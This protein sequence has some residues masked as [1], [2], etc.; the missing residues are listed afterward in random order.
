MKLGHVA[1]TVCLA[2]TAGCGLSTNES[3]EALSARDMEELGG[4]ATT[5][6]VDESGHTE[7]VSLWFVLPGED[8]DMLASVS[9][10]VI[11][12]AGEAIVLEELFTYPVEALAAEGMRPAIPRAVADAEIRVDGRLAE[13]DLPDRFYT[14]LAEGDG[15]LAFGQIVLTLTDNFPVELVQFK[16]NGQDVPVRDGSGVERG[17]PVGA[18]DFENLMAVVPD[19]PTILAD[20]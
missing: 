11:E 4:D 7:V 6:D 17:R 15:R 14:D 20:D 10:S 3:P 5:L 18:A 9:A 19:E 12:G 13:V 2:V 1:L 16:R 8:R